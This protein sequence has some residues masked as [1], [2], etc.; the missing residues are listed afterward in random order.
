MIRKPPF[1]QSQA[2]TS[3]KTDN[4]VEKHDTVPLGG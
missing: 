2:R 3:V 1:Y 4:S